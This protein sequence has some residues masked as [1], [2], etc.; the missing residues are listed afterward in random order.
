M[1]LFEGKPF[2]VTIDRSTA[3]RGYVLQ[4]QD[5]SGNHHAVNNPLKRAEFEKRFGFTPEWPHKAASP[6]T[7][8]S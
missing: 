2:T 5:A 7:Q 6:A 4:T 3:E 1:K 8:K